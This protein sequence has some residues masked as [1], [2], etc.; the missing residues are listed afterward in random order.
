VSRGHPRSLRP[1]SKVEARAL[2]HPASRKLAGI[3]AAW[4]PEGLRR[5]RCGAKIGT[6]V[7][8]RRGPERRSAA[9][10]PRAIR[11]VIVRALRRA[12][13][14]ADPDRLL[15]ST[16][17]LLFASFACRHRPA[18]CFGRTAARFRRRRR[19]ASLAPACLRAA[20][21]RARVEGPRAIVDGAAHRR[22]SRLRG[23]GRHVARTS[24][25]DFLV[26]CR[27]AV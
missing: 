21:P 4:S 12:T 27:L 6:R 2:R 19:R 14:P 11:I 8:A 10:R 1:F 7:P 9:A 17:F 26:R 20:P 3:R 25:I 15:M 5:P 18:C 23:P 16:R 13:P 24:S 22:P